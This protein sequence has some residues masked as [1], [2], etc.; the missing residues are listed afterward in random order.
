MSKPL[1]G[2]EY[3]VDKQSDEEKRVEQFYQLLSAY[4]L[5]GRSQPLAR[6]KRSSNDRR[7]PDETA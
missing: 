4:G 6:R 2:E 3:I 7:S 5:T 1:G